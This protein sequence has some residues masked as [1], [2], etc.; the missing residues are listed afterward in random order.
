MVN[1]HAR[2]GV[3]PSKKLQDHAYEL[4][5]LWVSKGDVQ[6]KNVRIKRIGITDCENV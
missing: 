5:S 2:K 1:C 6:R 4:K 3:H